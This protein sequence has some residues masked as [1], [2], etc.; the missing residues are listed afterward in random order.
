MS[1]R[2]ADVGFHAFVVGMLALM[3]WIVVAK[4]W[5]MGSITVGVLCT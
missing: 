2:W 5:G 3:W 4:A 1:G